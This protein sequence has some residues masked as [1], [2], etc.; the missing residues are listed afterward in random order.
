MAV[1]SHVG[2]PL[3]AQDPLFTD[4]D[5]LRSFESLVLEMTFQWITLA[6]ACLQLVV[7]ASASARELQV[8]VQ[9]EQASRTVVAANTV[10]PNK[11]RS[12]P[13]MESAVCK[14]FLPAEGCKFGDE[15]KYKH[16]RTNGKCLRCGAEGHSL[17]SCTRPS[18]DQV[19]K[20]VKAID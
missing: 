4:R 7:C 2:N 14:F 15:C 10:T 11:G 19:W 5:W 20:S 9:V 1:L 17:S 12:T 3:Q 8:D 18:S 6:V 16:P 13:A